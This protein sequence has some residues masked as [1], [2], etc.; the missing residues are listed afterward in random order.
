MDA[1][2]ALRTRRSVRNYD[3]DRTVSDADLK[4]MVDCARL[5]ASARNAQPWEFVV[6]RDPSMR[7][8]LAR[9]ATNGAFIADAPACIAV[10]CQ[11][12]DYF[13]E[14]G[15]AAT[16]NLLIAARALGLGSCW[17]AGHRKPYADAV[18]QLLGAPDNMLLV[19][20]VAVGYPLSVPSPAKR[21]LADVLHWEKF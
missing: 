19:S 13:L 11:K 6:V 10:F 2:E 9:L 12:S 21:P 18:R 3:R 5:A 15:C 4:T 8:Q 16:Q 14:D 17:V 7:V 1:L 20:L